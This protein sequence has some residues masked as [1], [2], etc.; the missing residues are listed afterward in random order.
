MEGPEATGVCAERVCDKPIAIAKAKNTF[1]IEYLGFI[2]LMLVSKVRTTQ[3]R[4]I[5]A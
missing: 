2:K 5:W 1:F 3:V 4:S